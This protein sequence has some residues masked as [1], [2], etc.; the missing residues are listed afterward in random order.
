MKLGVRS[1]CVSK[2]FEEAMAISV[3][4][5]LEG[6]QITA[7]EANIFQATDDELLAFKAR[8]ESAGLAV[9]SSGAGPNL[10]DPTVRDDSLAKFKKIVHA[11]AVMGH[12]LVS[13]EVKALPEGLAPEDGW[14]SC[15]ANVRAVCEMAGSEGVD[16]CIEPGGPC[17]VSTTEDLE[18][19]IEAVDHDR[20]RVN[21]DGGNLW[22]AGS[23]SVDAARRLASRVS[24]VHIKD[25]SRATGREMAL[26]AGEVDYTAILSIL[27]DSGYSGW[28]V[29]ERERSESPEAD[30]ISAAARLRRIV[31]GL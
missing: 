24:H 15:I 4:A 8:V 7:R 17:L 12:G 20:L 21:F 22:N 13:A 2:D 16:L 10:V 6:I 18:R 23:D 28:L 9:A 25:W 3:K 5:G 31:E 26:G 1:I 30:T 29:I 19:I 27:R 14:E 11:A